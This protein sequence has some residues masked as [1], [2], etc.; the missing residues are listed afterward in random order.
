LIVMIPLTRVL[1]GSALGVQGAIPPLVASAAEI[2]ICP[3]VMSN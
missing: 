2:R 1:T 3:V